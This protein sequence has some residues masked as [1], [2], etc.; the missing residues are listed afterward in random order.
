MTS[1][2]AGG[3]LGSCY[4]SRNCSKNPGHAHFVPASD[5][6]LEHVDRYLPD[7]PS[8]LSRE[9]VLDVVKA[10]IPLTVR[11]KGHYISEHR[12]S[13]WQGVDGA[14][15]FSQ[16]RG[17][18]VSNTGSG[19]VFYVEE[20]ENSSPKSWV[21]TVLTAQH[22]VY[23]STKDIQ[24]IEDQSE[25]AVCELSLFDDGV[26]TPVTLSG[27]VYFV[28]QTER[29][30]CGL[31][32]HTTDAT[33]GEKLRQLLYKR[34]QV[35]RRVR[36][37]LVRHLEASQCTGIQDTSQRCPVLAITYPHSKLCYV[38]LGYLT[39]VEEDGS[40]DFLTTVKYDTASCPGSSGGLIIPLA[41]LTRW[42]DEEFG[43]RLPNHPHS[44][45]NDDGTGE[46]AGSEMPI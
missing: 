16:Y 39:G 6:S 46:S 44:G 15:P 14:Y 26:N 5:F 23:G 42:E 22:V 17:K 28:G 1:A 8:W 7:L 2:E 27:G 35:M 18:T 12:P 45:A 34:R 20:E 38:T 43:R 13:Q 25:A 36:D 21:I 41:R 32:F 19:W 4:K 9:D 29:D 30:W 24:G 33:L 11:I 3:H 10:N 37:K 40:Y 31:E